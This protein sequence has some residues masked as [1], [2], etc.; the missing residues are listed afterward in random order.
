MDSTSK[1]LQKKLE[2]KFVCAGTK[3]LTII[4]NVYGPPALKVLYCD[5]EKATL[6]SVLTGPSNYKQSHIFPVLLMYSDYKTGVKI[7]IL[8]LKSLSGETSVIVII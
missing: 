7:K 8:K 1:L 5:L 4:L 3:A 2:P 6:I